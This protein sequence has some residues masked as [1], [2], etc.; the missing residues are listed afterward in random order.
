MPCR[1]YESDWAY[2]STSRD[3]K[4]IKEEAD[5]LARIACRAMYA[6][7]KLDPELK[8]IRDQESRSW[9]VKHKVADQL[10]VERENKEK[11]KKEQADKL[12]K[13]ALAKLTPEEIKA[14]GI[15]V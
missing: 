6:L 12:R 4:R 9:W 11:A 3:V 2:D 15:K 8:S 14:F 1:S 13:E 5:K 10:R 7:E